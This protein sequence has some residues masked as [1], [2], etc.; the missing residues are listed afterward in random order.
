VYESDKL[1]Q[2]L[3][4]F[5]N[6]SFKYADTFDRKRDE[7][8]IEE[9]MQVIGAELVPLLSSDDWEVFACDEV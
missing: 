7:V 8:F 5:G 1:Y 4:K 9:R 2:F 3:L 6:L